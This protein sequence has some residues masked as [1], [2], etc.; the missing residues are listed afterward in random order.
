MG[1]TR[2]QVLRQVQLPLAMP[3]IMLGVNQTLM[4]GLSMLVI[5]ALVGTRNLGQETL[6]ALSKV[7]PG[8]GVTAGACVALIAIVTD[9]LIGAWAKR[10]KR[11]LGIDPGTAG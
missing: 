1:C 9:R 11:E 8:R 10:R 4:M 7:D 3:D 6:I 2:A 5:T